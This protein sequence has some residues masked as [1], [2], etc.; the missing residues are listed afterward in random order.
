MELLKVDTENKNVTLKGA[1]FELRGSNDEVLGKYK[2]DANGKLVIKD[3]VFGD[4]KLIE[5]IAPT[6]S[7]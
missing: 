5:T 3:L 7:T 6:D 4:Y 2:T 1:E